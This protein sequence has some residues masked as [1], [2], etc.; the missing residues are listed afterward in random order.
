MAQWVSLSL[1][2]VRIRQMCRSI[3]YVCMQLQIRVKDT[4]MPEDYDDSH[5]KVFCRS[6]HMDFIFSP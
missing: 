6:D 1:S 3:E 2:D 5:D 4:E